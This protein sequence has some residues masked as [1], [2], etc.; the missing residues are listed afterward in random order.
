ML[1]DGHTSLIIQNQPAEYIFV[2]ESIP[3]TFV[4]LM[5]S[6]KS[7]EEA[8]DGWKLSI[9]HENTVNF[10]ENAADEDAS[11]ISSNWIQSAFA[12]SKAANVFRYV[13]EETPM[14]SHV[15][16]Y[17]LPPQQV[18]SSSSS[19]WEFSCTAYFPLQV[20]AKA[21]FLNGL[22][23]R[24]IARIVSNIARSHVWKP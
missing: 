8:L 10:V 11:S 7:Y 6:S 24:S 4:A 3:I 19:A 14:H 23:S 13:T 12:S 17:I 15:M 1:L 9:H 21:N 5:L 2:N 16:E 18:Y 20:S 22:M